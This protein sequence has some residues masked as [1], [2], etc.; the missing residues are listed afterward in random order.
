MCTQH[1]SLTNNNST[2]SG[3]PAG[4]PPGSEGR[5]VSSY[6][7][8][9]HPHAGT[10]E[11]HEKVGFLRKGKYDSGDVEGSNCMSISLVPIHIIH[12][13]SLQMR[14]FKLADCLF[15]EVYPFS[16]S[17]IEGW[18]RILD[19]VS[20]F[21]HW[22]FHGADNITSVYQQQFQNFLEQDLSW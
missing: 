12:F 17:L 21:K 6:L 16:N 18:C 1:S 20:T 7:R 5:D 22:N 13:L 9:R 15:G 2:S 8:N 3:K 14:W 4:I 10:E 19:D 11:G